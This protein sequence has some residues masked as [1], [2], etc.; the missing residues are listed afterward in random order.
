MNNTGHVEL[1]DRDLE[2][3]RQAKTFLSLPASQPDSVS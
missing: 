1:G 3:L 2:D